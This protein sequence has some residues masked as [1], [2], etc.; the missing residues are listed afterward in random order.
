MDHIRVHRGSAGTVSLR[1]SAK[2]NGR[3]RLFGLTLLVGVWGLE[4]AAHCWLRQVSGLGEAQD[5]RFRFCCG[6]GGYHISVLRGA[7]G[8]IT[9]LFTEQ[10]F[11]RLVYDMRILCTF[12]PPTSSCK[13]ARRNMGVAINPCHLPSTVLDLQSTPMKLVGIHRGASAANS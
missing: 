10:G 7:R 13:V 2:T 12:F 5:L 3:S 4:F 1:T 9:I 6:G 11:L 8:Q